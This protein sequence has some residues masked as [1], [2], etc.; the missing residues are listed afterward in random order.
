MLLFGFDQPVFWTEREAGL[1]DEMQSEDAGDAASAQEMVPANLCQ[2]PA[3][4]WLVIPFGAAVVSLKTWHRSVMHSDLQAQGASFP[5]C[6]LAP[7][8]WE[9][10]C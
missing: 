9:N 6:T 3:E 4:P 1:A 8:C 2:R 5:Y 7:L 10:P